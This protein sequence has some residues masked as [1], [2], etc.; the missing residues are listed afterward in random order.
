MTANCTCLS[1]SIVAI[2]T[3]IGLINWTCVGFHQQSALVH[4]WKGG[5]C[6]CRV[7]RPLLQKFW[8]RGKNDRRSYKLHH[9]PLGSVCITGGWKKTPALIYN[10]LRYILIHWIRLHW[11]GVH[12]RER[13]WIYIT[14]EWIRKERKAAS[15]RRVLTDRK[16]IT[17]MK[18]SPKR[19]SW[20]HPS[21]PR[22]DSNLSFALEDWRTHL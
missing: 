16:L 2:T 15:G 9:P 13:S 21:R 19:T 12:L 17:G 1:S 22:S 11:V 10:G 18:G 5:Q 8:A 4:D 6:T 7:F 14:F 20:S 3:I